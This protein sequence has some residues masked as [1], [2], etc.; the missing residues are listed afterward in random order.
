MSGLI[1]I[2]GV[3]LITLFCGFAQA[4]APQ[5]SPAPSPS[6][7]S[8][9]A[10]KLSFSGA[11][12]F[13]FGAYQGASS[14]EER[15]RSARSRLDSAFSDTLH[16]GSVAPENFEIRETPSHIE[17]LYRETILFTMT[18]GDAEASALSYSKESAGVVRENLINAFSEGVADRKPQSL[19]IAVASILAVSL[20]YAVLLRL[21]TT[22]SDKAKLFVDR[23]RH[24]EQSRL[25]FLFRTS[26]LNRGLIN[27]IGHIAVDIAAIASFL[28][29]T[30]VYIP[31]VLSFLPW[32][33][34]WAEKIFDMVSE[35]VLWI[36]NGAVKIV[37]NF[38]FIVVVIV[39]ARYLLKAVH[40]FFLAIERGTITIEGFHQDW[41]KPT[42]QLARIFVIL[43][44]VVMCFP[45]VPGSDS[46]AF[47][48][49][50]VF[51]G[52]LVSL[53]SSS[54]ISNMIAGVVMTYMRPFKVGDRV[55]IADTVGDVIEKELLV[56]RVRTIKNVDVTIPNSMILG[57][58]IVNYSAIASEKGLI[59]NATVT[60]GYDIPWPKVHEALI[61]AALSCEDIL[62]EPKPFIFQT[63]L[64][65]FNV[66]YELN[67]Y[68]NA[69]SKMQ[70]IYSDINTAVQDVFS[71]E[72]IEL[73]SP[74]YSALRDGGETTVP[75]KGRPTGTKARSV[76][77]HSI[78]A[79]E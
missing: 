68:T 58:H 33:Q 21:L 2:K 77:I 12:L 45:Y 66:S 52:V 22:V 25:A 42:Y 24:L 59:L 76:Q 54:A 36:W 43:L 55:K 6:S 19:A 74:T 57:S 67:A 11:T 17:F 47:Q 1:S 41:A 39:F 61:E 53:G 78:H 28:V 27:R 79:D 16:A 75:D 13:V 46:P 18:P 8:L 15:A 35:P 7:A 10:S 71:R 37:P 62:K 44:T 60:V 38:F 51:L 23:S 70:K 30:Y 20:I 5:P 40:F 32:T 56:T 64:N 49:I 48:G 34:G 26:I 31:V 14:P 69:A 9:N 63:A 72:K 73:L 50:S 4:A 3:I 65:S 29:L